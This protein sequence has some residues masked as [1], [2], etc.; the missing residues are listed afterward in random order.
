ML[1]HR[2]SRMKTPN[3][4]FKLLLVVLLLSPFLNAL[5]LVLASSSNSIKIASTGTITYPVP[6]SRLVGVVSPAWPH[7]TVQEA[8]LL[9]NA[10]ANVL[11]EVIAANWW[12]D[13]NFQMA[14]IQMAQWLTQRGIKYYVGTWG[15]FDWNPSEGWN[16]AKADVIMNA[17]GK[18]DLYISKY[19]S[20]IQALQPA[21]ID[22]IG[23]PPEVSGTTY[24]NTLN[25][26]Q[27]F[28][29][30]RQFVTRAIGAWRQIK[31]DLT[32]VVYSIPFWDLSTII[33]KP[34]NLPNIIL[35]V[36]YYYSYDGTYPPTYE[37]AQL[38][39]WNGNLQNAKTELYYQFLTNIG[40]QKALDAGFTV[41]FAEIGTHN[42]NPNALVF[43]QDVY[44][45]AKTYKI[46][47][48]HECYR[49]WDPSLG[50]YGTGIFQP[51]WITL[52][53][54]GQ[55]WYRNMKG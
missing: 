32:C 20:I 24:N 38:D 1:R 50:Y 48:L 22:V 2:V 39:Y 23:E 25:D 43:M 29:A 5:M 53:P 40:I 42:N 11:R 12:N 33:A 52:N 35:P 15:T 49:A 9:V 16:Q 44:D 8:D 45:F 27:W 6:K 41:I 47:I 3:S 46:G 37:H 14:H 4:A 26:A 54:L 19:S 21:M 10:G 17:S 13:T 34:I 7:F 30:Y 18:G 55:V 51:D 31:P 36:D 28:E